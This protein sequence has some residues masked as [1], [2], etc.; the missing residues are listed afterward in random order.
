[1]KGNPLSSEK[2]RLVKYYNLARI[3][4]LTE[5]IF[6]KHQHSPSSSSSPLV[7]PTN[8]TILPIVLQRLELRKKHQTNFISHLSSI[9][10]HL[11]SIIYHL[12]SSSSS[13]SSLN[14]SSPFPT[15]FQWSPSRYIGKAIRRD[16]RLQLS[17][18]FGQR[19]TPQRTWKKTSC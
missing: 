17:S 5:T 15:G 19:G 1:M 14:H 16:L 2:R 4:L 8:S 10:Y 9:I 7:F 12:S 3:N 13:S 11:S 18:W 6:K